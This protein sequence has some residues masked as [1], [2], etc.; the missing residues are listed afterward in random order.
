[1]SRSRYCRDWDRVC[2]AWLSEED[3]MVGW[4]RCQCLKRTERGLKAESSVRCVR[5]IRSLWYRR[6]AASISP[7]C[8]RRAIALTILENPLNPHPQFPSYH[9]CPPS[10]LAAT[11]LLKCLITARF[12]SR[13]LF[14][15]SIS[16]VNSAMRSPRFCTVARDISRPFIIPE[17]CMAFLL[18][19][20]LMAC[21]VSG[22]MG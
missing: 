21:W 19:M 14:N 12:V 9:L 20:A 5:M 1:M 10:F 4:V 16:P 22:G 11:S 7:N 17:V 15:P 2:A 8:S 6:F 13:S 18:Q 3:E